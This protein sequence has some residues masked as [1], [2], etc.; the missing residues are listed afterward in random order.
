MTNNAHSAHR[1]LTPAKLSKLGHRRQEIQAEIKKLEEEKAKIDGQIHTLDPD[2]PYAAGDLIITRTAFRGLDSA[3]IA[4]KFPAAKRPEFYKLSLDT[5]EF[6]KHFS[7]IEL[8]AFQ[9]V[10]YRISVKDA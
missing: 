6:K 5:A 2:T 8:E 9:T 3:V 10:S 7:A 4:K 1:Q